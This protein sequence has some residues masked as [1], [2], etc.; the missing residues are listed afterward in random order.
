M[1]TIPIELGNLSNLEV[2]SLGWNQL[3]GEIPP[4]LGT[5]S[6]LEKLRLQFNQLSGAIYTIGV[7]KSF[8]P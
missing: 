1:S 7:G 6:N 5:L 2:L 8:Q 4:Q 3:S